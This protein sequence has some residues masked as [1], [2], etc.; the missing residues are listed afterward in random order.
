MDFELGLLLIARTKAGPARHVP[1]DPRVREILLDLRSGSSSEWVFR[2]SRGGRLSGKVF[3]RRV[4]LPAAVRAG[5]VPADPPKLPSGRARRTLTW[6]SLRHTC[7][8]R[9]VQS[10]ADI[11]AVQEIMGH[12]TLAMTQ[13]YAHVETS[14]VLAALARIPTAPVAQDVPD[15]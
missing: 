11:R 3:Y 10:G 12:A 13:R 5:L 1:I 4:F 15:H 2:N 9:L 6:H 7:G 8:T 14:R